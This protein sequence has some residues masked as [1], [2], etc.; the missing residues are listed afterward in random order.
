MPL[1]GEFGVYMR[2]KRFPKVGHAVAYWIDCGDAQQSFGVCYG[3]AGGAFLKIKG[4]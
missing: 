1:V 3:L 2:L 4:V